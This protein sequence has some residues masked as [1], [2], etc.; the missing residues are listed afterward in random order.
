MNSLRCTDSIL[1]ISFFL[2]GGSQIAAA[3]S[4]S[5]RTEE[6]YAMDLGRLGAPSRFVWVLCNPVTLVQ[7]EQ[8][9]GE[10]NSQVGG[11]F[12]LFENI[13]AH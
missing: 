7:P 2:D 10:A 1:E 5:G 3:Y 12:D 8:V 13:I 4:I 11:M 6:V 9:M